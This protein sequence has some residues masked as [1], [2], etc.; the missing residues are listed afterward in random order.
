VVTEKRHVF[1]QGNSKNHYPLSSSLTEG[2]S[3]HYL[4]LL[5]YFLAV[6]NPP[7]CTASQNIFAVTN[8]K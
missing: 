1:Q 8:N 6:P 3:I 5:L 4:S 7:L 2:K